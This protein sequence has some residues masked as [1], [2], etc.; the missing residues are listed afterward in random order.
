MV[1]LDNK[2]IFNRKVLLLFDQDYISEEKFLRKLIRTLKITFDMMIYQIFPIKRKNSLSFEGLGHL[3]SV[4]NAWQELKVENP[5]YVQERTHYNYLN[6]AS[7]ILSVFLG[8]AMI[9]YAAG[10][11]FEVSVLTTLGFGMFMFFSVATASIILNSGM[12]NKYDHFLFINTKYNYKLFLLD[13]A[14]YFCRKERFALNL[15]REFLFKYNDILKIQEAMEQIQH[16]ES[17]PQEIIAVQA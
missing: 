17:H 6:T 3:E 2:N 10:T 7:L 9:L 16:K 4:R 15:K 1:I 12:D 14:S 13:L 11:L 8:I 5:E